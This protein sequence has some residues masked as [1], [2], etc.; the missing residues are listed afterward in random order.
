MAKGKRQTTMTHKTLH[1][2][3][4]IKKHLGW[5]QVLRK[6]GRLNNTQSLPR[7]QLPTF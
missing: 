2:K 4:K 6:S 5:T 1:R 3:H 7:I